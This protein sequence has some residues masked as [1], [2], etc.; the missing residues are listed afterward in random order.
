MKVILRNL[1]PSTPLNLDF[2]GYDVSPVVVSIDPLKSEI[3]DTS[4]SVLEFNKISGITAALTSDALS[5]SARGGAGV[6]N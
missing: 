1:Q 5:V 3:V 4:L 2:T 6:L